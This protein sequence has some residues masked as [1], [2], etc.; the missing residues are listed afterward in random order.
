M[1]RKSNE[2]PRRGD[3]GHLIMQRVL[4]PDEEAVLKTRVVIRPD[5]P[6]STEYLP[7]R[8]NELGL[9]TLKKVAERYNIKISI[10]RGWMR[11]YDSAPAVKGNLVGIGGPSPQIYS[12]QELVIF[13][14]K[15]L[16]KKFLE[17][18]QRKAKENGS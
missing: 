13:V 14:E 9:T 8:A 16:N 1:R 4:S 17:E 7:H 12:A 15:V 3:R 2:N 5:V 11:H 10:L 18:M 6:P